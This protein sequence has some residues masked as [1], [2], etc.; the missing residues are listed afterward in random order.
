MRINIRRIYETPSAED[1]VR[2][3]VDR[4][5]PRGLTKERAKIDYWVRDA[6]PSVALR[7]WFSHD[8]EKWDTFKER[9]LT[10]LREQDTVLRVIRDMAPGTTVTLLFAAKDTKLNNAVVLKEYLE[11]S[12]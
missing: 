1:G 6:A 2:I 11:Q 12:T 9:Y 5:W 4:L 7:R 3:L 10:E 8:P